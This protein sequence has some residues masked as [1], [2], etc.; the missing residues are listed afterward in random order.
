MT[1]MT[2]PAPARGNASE[3]SEVLDGRALRNTLGRF[4]TGVTVVTSTTETG[5][6]VG[7]T[8]NSFSS[9]SLEPAL[10]LWSLVLS[11]PNLAAFAEGR[12]FAVNILGAHQDEL[13]MQ[14]ARSAEDKFAGVAHHANAHGVPLLA[15]AL[16]RLE[17]R[18]EFTRIAGDHLLIVGRVQRFD[19]EEGEP[20][21]FYQGSF[22]RVIA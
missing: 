21:V 15:G 2:A 1:N 9:L 10:I 11:S 13:A 6:P 5:A 14:F 7:I 12:P 18:V 8:A 20:L 19:T 17:C 16:A 22:Q 3:F 4:A